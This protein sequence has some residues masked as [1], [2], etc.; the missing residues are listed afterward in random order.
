MSLKIKGCFDQHGET[1]GDELSSIWDARYWDESWNVSYKGRMNQEKTFRDTSVGDIL[2]LNPT[3]AMRIH[4]ENPPYIRAFPV[5][6]H[7]NLIGKK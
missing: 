7:N 2:T 5:R 4:K 3:T 1:K 6:S